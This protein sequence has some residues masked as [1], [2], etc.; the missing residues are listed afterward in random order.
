[1]LIIQDKK[2]SFLYFKQKFKKLLK[3]CLAT[4]QLWVNLKKKSNSN[5]CVYMNFI[6]SKILVFFFLN[7]F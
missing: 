4:I 2:L 7:F 1:M 3:S 6:K 5:N